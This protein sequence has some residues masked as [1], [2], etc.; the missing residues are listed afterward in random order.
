MHSR[1]L[2]AGLK[3]KIRVANFHSIVISK[4]VKITIGLLFGFI[5]SIGESLQS[6]QCKM[7]SEHH[8]KWK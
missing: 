7:D 1:I 6:R 4:D 5:P 2:N 3:G 8:A